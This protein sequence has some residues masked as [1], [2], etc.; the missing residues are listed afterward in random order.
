MLKKPS[1][2]QFV[3]EGNRVRH[4]P[5]DAWWSAYPHSSEPQIHSKGMLGSVLENGDDYDCSE[6]Q[7]M[8]LRIL[9]ESLKSE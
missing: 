3:L 9:R 4:V 7:S 6:V 8:A 1:E 2:D 5:T